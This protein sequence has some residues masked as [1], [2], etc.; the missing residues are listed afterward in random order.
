MPVI[1]MLLVTIPVSAGDPPDVRWI[2][3]ACGE[4]LHHEVMR[5]RRSRENRRRTEEEDGF[6]SFVFCFIL[7]GADLLCPF[8]PTSLLG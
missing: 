6:S 5:K 2:Q 3:A 7:I 1:L 8:I 4:Q